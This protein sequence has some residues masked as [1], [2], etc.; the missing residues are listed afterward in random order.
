MGPA[1]REVCGNTLHKLITSSRLSPS[2]RDF[3]RVSGNPRQHLKHGEKAF[4]SD[5]AH[6]FNLVTGWRPQMLV[7]WIGMIKSR[8]HRKLGV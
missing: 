4:L 1:A 8:I 3:G 2:D 7:G 6:I 5:K